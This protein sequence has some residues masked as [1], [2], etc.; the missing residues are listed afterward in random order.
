MDVTAARTFSTL[1]V[2]MDCAWLL[3]FAAIL[4]W[5]KKYFPSR[6]SRALAG[7]RA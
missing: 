5:R 6:R 4:A 1:F 2:W 3:V 7:S